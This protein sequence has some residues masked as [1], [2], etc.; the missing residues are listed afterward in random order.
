M[1]LDSGYF[2]RQSQ[3]DL[4]RKIYTRGNP[5]DLLLIVCEGKKTEPNYFKSFRVSSAQVKIVG[6]GV[7]T[8]SLVEQTIVYK[9]DAAKYRIKYDQIWCVFDR[10]NNTCQNIQDAF[11]L[12]KREGV[13]I[14]FSNEAFELWYLLHFKYQT[15]FLDRHECVRQLN[16]AAGFKYKKNDETMYEKILDKQVLAINN[17]KRLLTQYVPHNPSRDN[18]STTVH[19]LVEQLNQFVED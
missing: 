15:T 19:V 8:L 17:A 5:K 11:V 7:N 3:K 6:L 9:K 13:N 2:K 18:P 10:D 1:N 12:A 4:K 16:S 14:A